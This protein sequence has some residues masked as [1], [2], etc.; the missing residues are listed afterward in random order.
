MPGATHAMHRSTI[1]AK[2]FKGRLKDGK[3]LLFVSV[4]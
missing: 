3:V 2:F 4:Y 1:F